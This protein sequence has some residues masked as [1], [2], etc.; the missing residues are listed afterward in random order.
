M[1]RKPAGSTAVAPPTPMATPAPAPAPAAATTPASTAL[2]VDRSFTPSVQVSPAPLAVQQDQ[3][4]A[5][6][7][8]APAASLAQMSTFFEA[9]LR[10]QREHD[11]KTRHEMMAQVKRAEAQVEALREEKYQ[12]VISDDELAALQQRAAKLHAAQ[13]LADEELFALED[14]CADYLEMQT[15]AGGVLTQEAVYRYSPTGAA[16]RLAKLAGLSEGLA[17]DAAF[18]R[19][20]RRKFV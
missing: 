18:A 6:F 1:A 13:L 14:L 8:S 7:A 9:Q 3:T 2:V 5:G 10:I 17:S 11:E 12:Q 16:T 15:A 20:A 4:D 19:Q